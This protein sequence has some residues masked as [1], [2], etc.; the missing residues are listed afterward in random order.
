METLMSKEMWKM[1]VLAKLTQW[2]SSLE[3]MPKDRGLLKQSSEDTDYSLIKQKIF[4]TIP[5]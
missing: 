3:D 2:E 5:P 1:G 4:V